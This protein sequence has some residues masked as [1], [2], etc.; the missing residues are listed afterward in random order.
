MLK[1][2]ALLMTG[3]LLLA[4][5]LMVVERERIGEFVRGNLRLAASGVRLDPQAL[6]QRQC[7]GILLLEV[8][9]DLPIGVVLQELAF[10]LELNGM[11]VGKGMQAVPN[12]PVKAR[13][14]SR[15]EVK[16]AVD[17]DAARR[18][19]AQTSP[20]QMFEVARALT[21]RLRGRAG[22]ANLRGMARIVGRVRFRIDTVLTVH[23]GVPVDLTAD[24]ERGG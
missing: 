12:A 11:P 10:D 24:F 9:N 16:F 4:I 19:L 17:G 18:A 13:A 6:T 20:A 2:I 3:L 5:V 7:A 23:V 14:R 1:R 21:D 22:V 8:E 15:V